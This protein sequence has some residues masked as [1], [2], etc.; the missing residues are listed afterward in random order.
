MKMV[1]YRFGDAQT[2]VIS[3]QLRI[4]GGAIERIF[5]LAKMYGINNRGAEFVDKLKFDLAKSILQQVFH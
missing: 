4:L 5:I 3:N 2:A 1:Q